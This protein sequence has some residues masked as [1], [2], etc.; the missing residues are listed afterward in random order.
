MKSN[1]DDELDNLIDCAL[2]GYSGAEP[3]AGLEERV[4]N[5]TRLAGAAPRRS[6]SL[7]WALAFSILTSLVFGAIVLRTQHSAAPKATDVAR[8]RTASASL[9]P[10]PSLNPAVE[11]R[12]VVPKHRGRIPMPSPSPKSLPR[13]EQFPARSL[14]TGEE[15][16]LLAFIE[17]HPTEAR[18]AFAELQK[19]TNEEINI[20]AIQIR[21]LQ[22]DGVQ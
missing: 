5:R 9:R 17:T 11:E 22:S 4:L 16:V 3:L 20:Q 21:P 10:V 1:H 2:P 14:I 19:R 7:R 12:R 18:Q 15:R 13:Q 8:T 6:K